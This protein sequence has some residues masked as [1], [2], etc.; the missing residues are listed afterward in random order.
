MRFS[1]SLST[2]ASDLLRRLGFVPQAIF[3]SRASKLSISSQVGDC[4]R[5]I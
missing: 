1:S 2:F 4:G 3:S 5:S